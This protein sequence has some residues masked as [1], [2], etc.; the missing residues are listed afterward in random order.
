MSAPIRAPASSLPPSSSP[1]HSSLEA[2]APGSLQDHLEV[3]ELQDYR[4]RD[5]RQSHP[6]LRHP[7]P[8]QPRHQLLHS[9]QQRNLHLQFCCRLSGRRSPAQYSATVINQP[10]GAHAGPRRL[11]IL[12]GRLANQ[13]QLHARPGRSLRGPELD[14]RPYQLGAAPGFGLEPRPPQ[15]FPGK[16][17]HSRRLRLVLRPLYRPQ[18][19][20][21]LWRRALHHSDPPR[22]S[23]QSAELRGHAS[24]PAGPIQF[25]IGP[26]LPH[27]RPA[28]QGGSRHAGGSGNRSAAHQQVDGEH[29]LPLHPGRA[30]VHVK[31]RDRARLQSRNLHRYRRLALNLQ[32]PV[33]IWRRSSSSTR[34]S[35]PAAF[36]RGV[37]SSTAPT[38]S[39]SPRAIRRES[40][41]SPPSRRIPA[42]TTAAP[43]SAF[44]TASR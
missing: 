9:R 6:A 5:S 3:F 32:L 8:R 11:G 23:H 29:H 22:Q 17:R 4:H 44:A 33:P 42:S 18:R 16:D 39:T 37:S 25:L 28:L 13:A 12:P 2:T 21:F 27:H 30:S 1:A 19:L 43:P 35:S 41:R 31:Q 10:P 14:P 15:Q 20:Q 34:S 36:K 38:P 24:N 26:L 40:I 7:R